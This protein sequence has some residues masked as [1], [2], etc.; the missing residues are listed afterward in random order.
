MTIEATGKYIQNRYLKGKDMDGMNARKQAIAEIAQSSAPR[1]SSLDYT[2][3]PLTDIYGQNVFSERVMRERLPK[4]VFQKLN[5]TMRKGEPLDPSIADIVA[6]A[7]KD[8]AIEK[9]ATH[10]THWF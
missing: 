9:G 4:G 8:W 2:K 3:E 1:C 7:M 6:N 5:R 10:Y